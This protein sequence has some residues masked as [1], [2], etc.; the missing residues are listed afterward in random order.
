MEYIVLNKSRRKYLQKDWKTVI[1]F[2][3]CYVFSNLEIKRMSW[4]CFNWIRTYPKVAC[5]IGG[6]KERVKTSHLERNSTVDSLWKKMQPLFSRRLR[7]YSGQSSR[8]IVFVYG[9]E[10]QDFS[11]K[12]WYYPL[13]LW[14]GMSYTHVPSSLLSII[15]QFIF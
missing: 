15:L 8:V 12:H 6:H 7:R 1:K 5:S 2:T 3:L 11:E 4:C 10:Q 9:E 13:G 14:W